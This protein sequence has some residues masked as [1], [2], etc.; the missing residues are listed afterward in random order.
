M[1]TIITEL[2][3]LSLVTPNNRH[4]WPREKGKGKRE[5]HGQHRH[6]A[7]KRNFVN[8]SSYPTPERG[9]AFTRAEQ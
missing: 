9:S 4:G 2:R 7:R 8:P 5:E 3:S 1:I 6:L